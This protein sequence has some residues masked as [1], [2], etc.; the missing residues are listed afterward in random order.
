MSDLRKNLDDNALW[1]KIIKLPQTMKPAPAVPE[2]AEPFIALI[3]HPTAEYS[4]LL[5]PPYNMVFIPL[6]AA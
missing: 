6:A 3:S 2:D 1:G 4:P 5:S